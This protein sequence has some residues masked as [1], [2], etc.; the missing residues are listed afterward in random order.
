MDLVPAGNR[1]APPANTMTSQMF[2]LTSLFSIDLSQVSRVD[3]STPVACVYMNDASIVSVTHTADSKTIIG[4]LNSTSDDFFQ[5]K[6]D[7]CIAREFL[8][9]A[10]LRAILVEQATAIPVL[11]PEDNMSEIDDV[12]DE[13]PELIQNMPPLCKA[14]DDQTQSG[15]D[16]SSSDYDPAEE[17]RRF[18]NAAMYLKLQREK[19]KVE[20][21]SQTPVN[22][23]AKF[24][25]ASLC[26]EVMMNVSDENI[27]N[28]LN[29]AT[30][31]FSKACSFAW[32]CQSTR[33][34][35]VVFKNGAS[36]FAT[37]SYFEY[38]AGGHFD[39]TFTAV[40]GKWT[41][42]TDYLRIAKDVQE[43]LE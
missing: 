4:V 3:T 24:D 6:V 22:L 35:D 32:V 29:I 27:A 34:F 7:Q 16:D 30:I 9:S 21:E 36:M 33:A 19:K 14:D 31:D 1:I 12:D 5:Q 42:T 13:M 2:K 20:R 37:P 28:K 39:D 40:G 10:I 41:N 23:Q 11:N 38:R 8:R 15:D 25:E 17:A 43:L 18:R 26:V